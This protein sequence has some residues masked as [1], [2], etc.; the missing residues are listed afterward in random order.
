M[1]PELEGYLRERL[2][3]ERWFAS[4]SE[5]I[6][7]VRI[8]DRV[9]IDRAGKV[10]LI[11]SVRVTF[12]NSSD[13]YMVYLSGD[14]T[15]T[16]SCRNALEDNDFANYLYDV[17][18]N[19]ATETTESGSFSGENLDPVSTPKGSFGSTYLLQ[20]DQSNSSIVLDNKVIMKLYRKRTDLLTPD[21]QIPKALMAQTDYSGTPALLGS[22]S[23]SHD[24]DHSLLATVYR[25]IENEGDCWMV[26]TDAL[27]KAAGTGQLNA[28][29]LST[30]VSA[31]GRATAELH[32]ALS[33][34]RGDH[35][36]PIPVYRADISSWLRELETIAFTFSRQSHGLGKVPEYHE[37]V[38]RGE[39]LLNAVSGER[40]VKTRIHGDYHLGQVLKSADKYFIIDF[41]GEP[42]RSLEYR[43]HRHSPVK[44]VAGMLRSLSYAASSCMLE[45]P[46]QDISERFRKWMENS[47]RRFIESYLR[48]VDRDLN[49]L[50]DSEDVFNQMIDF[51][52]LEKALYEFN[53]EINNRP[54]WLGFPLN[55]IREI[56]A[57][58]K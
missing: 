21:Y 48:Y 10:F 49:Y 46:D 16:E 44:D 39:S 8:M 52:V 50:P 35:L 20:L 1:F 57:A 29:T 55:A 33:S 11:C 12:A 6:S 4:K 36:T 15:N 13:K 24:G 23:Y 31:L 14:G 47:S 3:H 34:L 5:K 9:N 41:E 42:M 17:F 2:P 54:G 43:R 28:K 7:D 56:M 53:Y 18:W 26:F 19:S 51:F 38:I 25:F 40:I 58:S 45:Y 27:K 30:E 22:I 37:I 32:N